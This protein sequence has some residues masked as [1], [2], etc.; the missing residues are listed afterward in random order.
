VIFETEPKLFLINT[1]TVSNETISLLSVRFT[2]IKINGES[3]PKQRISYQGATKVM[4]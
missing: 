2:D 1:I 3:K 4:A